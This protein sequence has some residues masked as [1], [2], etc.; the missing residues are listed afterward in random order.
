[1]VN[2]RDEKALPL[3]T[4]KEATCHPSASGVKLLCAGQPVS[5]LQGLDGFLLRRRAACR[6]EKSPLLAQGA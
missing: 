3:R 4:G 6:H 2:F 1:M 5:N